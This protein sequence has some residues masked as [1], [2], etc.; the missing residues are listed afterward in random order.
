LRVRTAALVLALTVVGLGLAGCTSN[1]NG[2]VIVP[3]PDTTAPAGATTTST[4]GGT[5]T[6][7]LGTL[8]SS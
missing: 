7:P 6:T 4:V 3:P 2:G 5:P 8:P 1:D